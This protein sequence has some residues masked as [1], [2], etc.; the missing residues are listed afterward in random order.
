MKNRRSFL[1][2]CV[3]AV[4]AIWCAPPATEAAEQPPNI[5]Y[6]LADDKY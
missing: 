2:P 4:A 5:V 1:A 3:L 6:I